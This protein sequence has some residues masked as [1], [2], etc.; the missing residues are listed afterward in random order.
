MNCLSHLECSHCGHTCTADQLQ[1]VCR[2]CGRPLLARYDLQEVGR[3]LHR[4]DLAD[5]EPTL[6]RY[7]ELLPVRDTRQVLSLGEGLT[8]LLRA[9]RLGRDLGMHSLFI[10]EESLNPTG[11]FK[12][13]G[14]SVA[15]SRARELGVKEVALP[16]AGNAGS[17]AAAYSA[18]AGMLAHVFMPSDV[19]QPFLWECRAYGAD[20][21]LTDGLI[22]E[23]GRKA[24]EEA[25]QYGWFLLSTLREPYRIEGKKTLGFEIAE[26]LGWQLPEVI[27]Y[28]TGGG[29]G[30]IGLW[31]SFLELRQ[32][33]WVEGPPPRMVAVQPDGCAP[34]VRAYQEGQEHA[35]PWENARTVAAGLRVPSSLGDFLVLRA[36]RDSQGTAVAVSEEE[37]L[38]GQQDLGR[39]E[40]IFACPEGGA[41][42]AA[43]RNLLRSGWVSRQERVVLFNTG[44]GLRYPLDS[45]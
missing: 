20:I 28:P 24:E 35:R 2:R 29:T 34:I 26:Q 33:G 40:G 30:L 9:N 11:S 42:L 22:T 16:S 21:R 1:S 39:Q 41:T 45:A 15:V 31:K 13:R 14:L 27:L 36:L 8:P 19:P 23:S 32:L 25:R 38:L 44:T 37:L 17:A 10:K 4:E 12:A 5:R 3:R 6:W 18:R 7:H 43:L